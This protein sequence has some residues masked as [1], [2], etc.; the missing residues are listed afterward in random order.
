MNSP[1]FATITSP[2]DLP[3]YPHFNS[4]YSVIAGMIIFELARVGR[5]RPAGRQHARGLSQDGLSKPSARKVRYDV[6]RSPVG[7][8]AEATPA[9]S[10]CRYGRFS[11]YLLSGCG[12]RVGLNE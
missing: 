9:V 3:Q 2:I 5:R 1:D 6:R 8:T 11:S 12:L 4:T 10:D 7:S